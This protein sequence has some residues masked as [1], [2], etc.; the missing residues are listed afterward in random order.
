MPKTLSLVFSLGTFNFEKNGYF[1]SKSYFLIA[2]QGWGGKNSKCWENQ[3][4][5]IISEWIGFFLL[6]VTARRDAWNSQNS[7]HSPKFKD[8]HLPS[9]LSRAEAG[10]RRHFL[11]Y[12]NSGASRGFWPSTLA[13][14][15]SQ[16][17]EVLASAPETP[18]PSVS[19]STPARC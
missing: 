15:L 6:E 5:K 11:R 19:H 18:H 4:K 14:R 2:V 16:G 1:L 17:S 7:M 12:L 3:H 8:L 13:V 10:A 9:L